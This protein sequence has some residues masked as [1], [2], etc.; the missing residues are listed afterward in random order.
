[1]KDASD[2]LQAD[3][4]KAICS[5]VYEARAWRPGGIVA[6]EDLWDAMM[7]SSESGEPFPYVFLNS[8]D[9][10]LGG[11][12]PGRLTMVVSGSGM[13]KST[14]VRELGYAD[15]MSGLP[16]A[17]VRLEENTGKTGLGYVGL[18]LNRRLMLGGFDKEDPA[19][20]AAFEATVA[21]GRFWTYDHFGSMDDNDLL[22]KL[23]YL[24]VACG[25]KTIILDHLSIVV[26]GMD[27]EGDER[28]TIDRLM[29]ALRSLVENTGVSLHVVCHLKRAAGGNTSHEEGGRITLADLRGSQ[30]IAQLSD[31]VVAMERNQQADGE[32][33]VVVVATGEV[34]TVNAKD[35]A[36]WRSLK[37]RDTGY[38]G[39][40]GYTLYD[41]KTGRMLEVQPKD[42]AEQG[43][44]DESPNAGKEF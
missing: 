15:L 6:G 3:R 12:Y 10:G 21:N 43:F 38:T 1:M 18:H 44:K 2:L 19:I 7:A 30:S 23:R 27:A 40:M 25:A 35:V 11:R 34:L 17:D 28:R 26:S 14:A 9:T 39:I 29:T 24:A 5:A 16:I 20:R 36:L 31:S 13:G 8:T 33:E 41:K 4:V 22:S 37:A 32:I 42:E